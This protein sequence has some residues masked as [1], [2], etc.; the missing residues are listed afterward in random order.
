MALRNPEATRSSQNR[1]FPQ[2]E[3]E[4]DP[5]L[6]QRDPD[7]NTGFVTELCD[8]GQVTSLF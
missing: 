4:R 6:S 3:A 5:D 1:E 2:K 8:V 7:M